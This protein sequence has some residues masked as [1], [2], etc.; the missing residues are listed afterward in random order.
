MFGIVF[1]ILELPIN[2]VF[3]IAITWE[4]IE[5]ILKKKYPKLLPVRTQ[6]SWI[7]SFVDVLAV[8]GGWITWDYLFY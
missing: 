3:L 4:L 6:D 7:N 1:R 8:V 2:L 5:T